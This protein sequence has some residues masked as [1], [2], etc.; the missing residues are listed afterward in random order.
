LSRQ[1]KIVTKKF[2]H[3]TGVFASAESRYFFVLAIAFARSKGDRV[4]TIKVA[5]IA[6]HQST[7]VAEK[8]P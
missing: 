2:R 8:N 4:G 6:H 1:Q 7:I 5:P 3:G